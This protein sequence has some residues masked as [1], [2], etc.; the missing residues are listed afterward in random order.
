MNCKVYLALILALSIG[1]AVQAQQPS[2][3]NF[4][5]YTGYSPWLTWYQDNRAEIA[6]QR[7]SGDTTWLYAP[8]TVHIVGNNNGTG[9]FRFDQAIRVLCEM[10]AQYAPSHI[11]FYFM[12]GDPVQYH[13][14]ST[15]YQHDW[16]GGAEMI[17]AIYP[18][19]EDRLNAF[20][21]DDPAGN[22]GYSWKDAIVLGKGCSGP[23]NSTWAHEA[24][25]HFSLPHPFYGWE[26]HDDYDYGSP[27]PDN[28]DG[29]P[30]E[31]MDTSNCYEAGDRFCDTRPDYLNYR[32]PCD[33]NAQSLEL[34]HDP[35]GVPF[36][37]DGSLIMGYAYDACQSRFTD[38]QMEAMRTNLYTEHVQYLTTFE[39]G[40][41]I[42]DDAWVELTSPIDSQVVQYN[43]F[44]VVW[45][46]VPEATMY[47]VQVGMTP[48]FSIML[49]NGTIENATSVN[50]TK[51]IPNNRVLYWRVRAY[52]YWDVCQPDNYNQ[53]G[54]FRTHNFT[55]TSELEQNVSAELAPNPVAGGLPAQMLIESNDNMDVVVRVTDAAGRLCQQQNLR[56]SLGQNQVE[57]PTANLQAG[58]YIV[59]LEN[60]QGAL[61][62]R[63]AVTE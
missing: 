62:K 33:E 44:T 32:W 40:T 30:V 35:N 16:S 23:G 49:Y 27:A 14:N 37:S 7:G 63:L 29:Y 15:W 9:Y 21:V 57:I 18:G 28:W 6:Q 2:D 26:G 25:H 48:T 24:G 52:N 41:E 47:H 17:D 34:Q 50:I 3:K 10:N 46:P 20:V 55:A 58:L 42:A 45:N 1:Q 4:C 5:G 13:N 43:N 19:L 31:R 38:E 36:R 53:V 56:L 22:C 11:R 61:I 54:V 39:P 59:T 12:P 60:E 8:V 51:G